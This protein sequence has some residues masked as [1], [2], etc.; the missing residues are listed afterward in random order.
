VSSDGNHH[1][2][3]TIDQ[4]PVI[5]GSNQ[6][7]E[8]KQGKGLV[9]AALKNDVKHFVYSSVD[10]GGDASLD[11]PTPIPHFISKHNI[12]HHLIEKAKGTEMTWTILRPVAFFDNFTPGFTGK[13]FT[14]SWKNIVKEKPLQ[15]IAVADIGFFGAQAFLLPDQYQNRAVSLAG[16]EL[17]FDEM[18]K[19]FKDKTGQSP[20]TTFGFVGR[21]IM[22][23]VKDMGLM[24]QWFHDVG[25]GADIQALRQVHPELK[26]FGTW[27]EKES[28]FDTK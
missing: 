9:D 20:P 16:D 17:T 25:Y 21:I 15:L 7:A 19:V 22:S 24:F 4:V 5:G 26:D 11:N 27:L 18:A 1:S 12:E 2:E 14:T 6:E 10:R 8:E 23:T 28:G 3:L 13:V